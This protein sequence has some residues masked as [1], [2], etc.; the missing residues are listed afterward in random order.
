MEENNNQNQ[1]Q[2]QQY[3]A[4]Q[5]PQGAPQG[6]QFF[7]GFKAPNTE[8]GLKKKFADLKTIAMILGILNAVVFV[9]SFFIYYLPAIQI[10]NAANSLAGAFGGVY[11]AATGAAAG[12]VI[13]YVV[14]ACI[15]SIA[16]IVSLFVCM[17]FA[18]KE[19]KRALILGI[20]AGGID[21]AGIILVAILGGSFNFFGFIIPVALIV[22][23]ILTLN[24]YNAVKG[25][26]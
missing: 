20:I 14:I 8:E 12:K 16:F 26:K 17:V 10:A 13:A 4:P 15:V 3:Q 25:N 18:K 9:I 24:A 11:G 23:C 19:D 1:Q 22:D 5:Q 2:Y 7:Q 6:N 21:I